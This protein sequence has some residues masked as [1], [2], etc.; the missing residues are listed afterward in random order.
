M[1]GW[2]DVRI[3]GL[4]VL[5]LDRKLGGVPIIRIYD[6]GVRCVCVCVCGVRVYVSVFV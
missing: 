1:A 3:I 4:A 6:L 2:K 5:L